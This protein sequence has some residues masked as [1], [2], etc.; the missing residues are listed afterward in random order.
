MNKLYEQFLLDDLLLKNKVVMAPLTRSRAKLDGSPT[1]LMATYYQQRATA[2]LIIAE[3]T[4]ICQQGQGYIA[5]P[6]IYNSAHI[7]GWK[8]VVDQVHAKHGLICLQL[9]H[10]GR[11]SHT[12]F[13][14]N[15]EPPLAPSAIQAK[16][17]VYNDKG[18]LD[19][20]MPRALEENEIAEIVNQYVEAAKNAKE[21]GFDM[22]E[23]HAANGYLIDQFLRDQTNKR[24]DAYGGSIENRSRFLLEIIDAVLSVYPAS[25]IGCRIAPVSEF[26][27]ISDSNPKELFT[28]VAKELGKRKI[29]YL[30][31][32][33][34]NTGG[35][36]DNIEFDYMNLYHSFKASGGVASMAN[37]GYTK[38]LAESAQ[39]K[40]DLICFGRPFISNPDLVEKLKNNIPLTL[41]DEG[42]FYG[43]DE[44][45]YVDY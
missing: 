2:G 23:I 33:E 14:P 7:A 27:D 13:Q 11:I 6:G 20:S 5:T 15:Q 1:D 42:T 21:A 30:H 37:N 32:I 16:S 41:G 26:N 40:I 19:T 10:V 36:R 24:S 28:Y 34:G 12:D 22:V 18:F 31:I 29:G 25:R 4:Q 3:A 35:A 43:G 17:K 9:W 44:K 39:E 38:E 8:K 45:G